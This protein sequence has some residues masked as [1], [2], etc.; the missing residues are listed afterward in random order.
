MQPFENPLNSEK[1]L[2]V[3]YLKHMISKLQRKMNKQSEF[4]KYYLVYTLSR[5]T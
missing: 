3:Q 5:F 2:S 4:R 1:Y